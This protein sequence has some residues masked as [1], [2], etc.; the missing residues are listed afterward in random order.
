MNLRDYIFALLVADSDVATWSMRRQIQKRG[1][2]V[3][4][5]E[6]L[7]E[8]NRMKRDG[9]IELSPRYCAVNSLVWRLVRK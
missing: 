3:T 5:T 6:V 9:L 1:L 8:C 4:T 2:D 7:R